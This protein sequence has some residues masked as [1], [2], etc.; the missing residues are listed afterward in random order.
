MVSYL[1]FDFRLHMSRLGAKAKVLSVHPF[2]SV[3]RRPMQLLL[4]VM[5]DLL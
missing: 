5:Q 4:S 2:Q 1:L 3:R